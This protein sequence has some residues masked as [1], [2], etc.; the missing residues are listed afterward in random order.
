MLKKIP[1]NVQK[2][3]EECSRR[4]QGMLKKIQGMFNN[5]PRNVQKD[6]GDVREDSR[7][8]S[9]RLWG[10]SRRSR[11]MLVKISRDVEED[12]KELLAKILENAQKD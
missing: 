5:I 8:C 12:S 4:F 2:D 9:R 11:G 3:P 10:C 6:P 1:G 7:E